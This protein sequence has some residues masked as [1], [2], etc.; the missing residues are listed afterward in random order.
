MYKYCM[1]W[2]LG[3]KDSCVTTFMEDALKDAEA[4][5]TP[6]LYYVGIKQWSSTTALC[7]F[8]VY[9]CGTDMNFFHDN[10]FS[11]KCWHTMPLCSPLMDPFIAS[12]PVVASY[13]DN[14]GCESG[15]HQ[16]FIHHTYL[17]SWLCFIQFNFFFFIYINLHS[18][19]PLFRQY[20]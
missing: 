18:I 12:L 10:D 19:W 11:V 4:G 2:E 14:A 17:P 3:C 15:P 20:A 9:V 7:K 1:W 16:S 5:S 6:L 13:L 8:D